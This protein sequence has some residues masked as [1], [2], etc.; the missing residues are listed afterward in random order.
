M[1]EVET[2]WLNGKFVDWKD[3]KVHFLT[4]ALHY[5]SAVF[6]G[7]RC[8][9]TDKGPAIFR[10]KDHLKRLFFSADV[11][12]ITVPYSNDT[13]FKAAKD[14]VRKNKLKECYIRPLVFV[15]YGKMGLNP[16]GINVEAGIAAWP[17]GTYLGEEGVKNGI[18]L[19]ISSWVRPP[20]H[21]MPTHAKVSGN[22]VSSIL[23][24]VEAVKAGFD[25]ALMLDAQGNLAE[26]SGENIFVVKDN[27][28]MSP[29]TMK[30]TLDGITRKSVIRIAK[31]E[32]I[33]F[34]EREITTQET[35]AADEAFLTGTAAEVT[36]IRMVDSHTIGEGRPGPITKKLQD[37]YF[38]AIHGKLPKYESWLDF[39]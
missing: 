26:C 25:E 36:P 33:K 8:Y 37:T 7:I 35:L 11:L 6:E 16:I 21:F 27:V 15:G 32:G 5:G 18:R 1:E 38:D 24:K 4:H 34:E 3:A 10:L 17:W 9:N 29:P 12:G 23:A 39:V 31:D 14:V 19:K 28:L 13:L 2:I 22:Y 30:N 20:S